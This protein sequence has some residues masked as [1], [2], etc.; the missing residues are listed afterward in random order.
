M[1][2]KINNYSQYTEEGLRIVDDENVSFTS[3]EENELFHQEM[4]DLHIDHVSELAA[5][6]YFKQK[7]EDDYYLFG[8]IYPYGRP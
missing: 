2:T 4:A 8:I 1:A 6:R 7:E 5:E 3:N